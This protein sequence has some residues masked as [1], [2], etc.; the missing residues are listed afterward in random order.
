MVK[1][2][3]QLLIK[4]LKG[5]EFKFDENV[6]D[7][8]IFI[9]SMSRLVCMV[10]GLIL[11]GRFLFVGQGSKILGTN[12]LKV[13]RGVEIGRY[14]SIDCMSRCGLSIGRGSKIGDFCI[15]KVSGTLA[16]LGSKI[17]IGKNVG[18]GDFCHIGGSGGVIIGSESIFGAYVSVH[19]EN[20]LFSNPN[21]LI[22]EQGVER[23]PVSIGEN[24]WIGAKSTFLAG[25]GVGNNCI[26]AA[27]SVL[28]KR[29]PDDVIVAGIPAKVLRTR[30]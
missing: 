24:C 23:L 2:I 17:Q 30:N 28:T 4:I 15:I 13:S 18:I 16:D 22:R 1:K 9:I 11:T 3:I 8:Y 26:V 19:P 12:K 10:R 29:F 20:H 7:Y 6:T 25:S 27:G 21:K 5:R 14:S